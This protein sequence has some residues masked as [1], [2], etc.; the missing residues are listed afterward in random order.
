M[1][2]V[3]RYI[4]RF[5][6]GEQFAGDVSNYV[7]YTSDKSC[8]KDYKV[9]IVPSGFFEEGVYGSERT[10]P[11][12][13]LKK[14]EDIPFLFG[15][16]EIE[17][18]GDTIVVHADLV[19]SAYFLL[20]R[21]EEM[22]HRDLRDVHGR[23][24]GCESLPCRAGFIDRPIV[25]EYGKLLRKWLNDSGVEVKATPVFIKKVNLTHDIDAPFYCRTWRN[26]ARIVLSGQ[27]TV[28][29]AVR[30][31]N[32]PVEQDLNYTYPWLFEQNKALISAIGRDRCESILFFRAGG[33]DEHDK[34]HYNL[35][36]KDIRSLFDLCRKNGAAVGLHSS[37]QAGIDPSLILSEKNHLEDAFGAVVTQNRNHFLA[38]REPE[39]M[40]YLE[41]AGVTDDYTMGYADIAG[42]RLGTASS[43]HYINPVTRRLSTSLTL[44][45]LTIMDGTL[46]ERQYMNLISEDA[47]SYCGRLIENVRNTNGE[48]TILWHNTS[49]IEGNSY[50]KELYA[51]MV[52]LIEN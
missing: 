27:S 21:Y 24:P 34:P 10:N 2:E 19:A 15:T 1:T 37:Y 44:H 52:N 14:I 28:A 38:S 30:D 33:T 41:K 3:I 43:V 13:P 32:K 35:Y 6:I 8:F 51:K 16:P 20:S 12:F 29:A 7:G 48:L 9:V 46:N 17:R 5:M 4:L 26:V 23:F 40:E 18:D 11:A 36:G 47:E 25:D 45:P 42:F 22:L 39:D 50:L 49:A 31:K